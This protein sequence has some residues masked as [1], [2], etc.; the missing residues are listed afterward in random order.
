MARRR[1]KMD[2]IKA[3]VNGENPFIQ[4]GY[5]GKH[6]DRKLGEEWTDKR[7][8]WKKTVNGIVRV[9]KQMDS[10]RELVR[11]RCSV[12]QTDLGLFGDKVD[13]KIYAKTGMC[14]ACVE[15]KEQTL[16]VTGK[17]E[18]YETAKL[19][20]NRMSALREFRRNVIESI[21]YLK[22]DDCK[23]EMVCSNGDRIVWQGAQ[24]APL[25]AAA[26]ADLIKVNEEI[27]RVEAEMYGKS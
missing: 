10:I 16:K 22:K 13:K 14:F 18:E 15:I 3:V 8:T 21:E 24:N 1:W 5:T 6:G 25:L 12:C 2:E 9:N 26:E 23:L 27:A 11:M 4:S 17:F 19:E 20:K 7:G